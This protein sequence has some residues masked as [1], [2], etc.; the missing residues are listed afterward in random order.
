MR[1]LATDHGIRKDAAGEGTE[2]SC[3]SAGGVRDANDT[4]V[5]SVDGKLVRFRMGGCRVQ[6]RERYVHQMEQTGVQQF[7]HFSD[8]A[9]TRDEP[10]VVGLAAVQNAPHAI[11]R[12]A[13]AKIVL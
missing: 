3:P 13:E 9:S 1:V 10:G 12:A 11:N 7:A 5:I 2:D 6:E 8:I 4:A